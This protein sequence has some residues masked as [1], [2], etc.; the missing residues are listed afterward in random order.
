MAGCFGSGKVWRGFFC[1]QQP[2]QPTCPLDAGL[3]GTLHCLL[4]V[5]TACLGFNT[6]FPGLQDCSKCLP[7][8]PQTLDFA[9]PYSTLATFSK[10]ALCALQVLLDCFLAALW[11]SQV[12]FWASLVPVGRLLD[13]TW[14]LLGSI[15]DLLGS[16]WTQSVTS[17]THH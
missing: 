4:G 17:S 1:P 16:S 13:P 6:A 11:A 2:S 8:A 9:D 5:S 3:P 10:I 15:F 7:R 14:G 12:T